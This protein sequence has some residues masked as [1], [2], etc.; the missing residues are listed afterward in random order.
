[1]A[2]EVAFGTHTQEIERIPSDTSVGS[3]K[4][5]ATLKG[6]GITTPDAFTFASY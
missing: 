2:P 3:A 1:V 6:I 4:N 5:V